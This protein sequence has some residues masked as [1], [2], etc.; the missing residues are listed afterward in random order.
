MSQ[1]SIQA[2]ARILK[3]LGLPGDLP[4]SSAQSILWNPDNWT[5]EII[6]AH[7][8][9][10]ADHRANNPYFEK[11]F[12]GETASPLY[13][14][15]YPEDL[16]KPQ[17]AAPKTKEK[18]TVSASEPAA[19]PVGIPEG[20]DKKTYGYFK[21]DGSLETDPVKI[22]A[23]MRIVYKGSKA[24]YN[25][26]GTERSKMVDTDLPS[27]VYKHPTS[28]ASVEITANRP[29]KNKENPGYFLSKDRE[30]GG[31]LY[32]NA[33]YGNRLGVSSLVHNVR[34]AYPEKDYNYAPINGPLSTV[35]MRDGT[36][37]PSLHASEFTEDLL[38]THYAPRAAA[39][40]AARHEILN[41]KTNGDTKNT[42]EEDTR[43]YRAGNGYSAE[44]QPEEE[45]IPQPEPIA[46][47][48]SQ[49]DGSSNVGQQFKDLKSEEA[50]TDGQ[51][52]WGE[53]TGPVVEPSEG[54]YANPWPAVR[55][56]FC[57]DVMPGQ[58]YA[59]NHASESAVC[60]KARNADPRSNWA[61]SIGITKNFVAFDRSTWSKEVK[62]RSERFQ[63][64]NG[65]VHPETGE[66]V[67]TGPTEITPR[68]PEYGD[69][70]QEPTREDVLR[71]WGDFRPN[72][73]E[74]YMEKH[75][76]SEDEL[77][78]RGE[79]DANK[80]ASAEPA[81]A[82]KPLTCTFCGETSSD[83][84]SF[85]KEH[86]IVSNGWCKSVVDAHNSLNPK[87]PINVQ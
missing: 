35:P 44:A 3:R 41:S 64:V 16:T 60:A 38:R 40:I 13:K 29:W 67:H 24:Y 32:D 74:Y 50:S 39:I 34:T 22:A 82:P 72:D 73:L 1:Y 78:P 57:G 80:E 53:R 12:T 51:A 75:G 66:A 4:T 2:R 86:Q 5:P 71:M 25:D 20:A 28:K 54:S 76:I 87:F 45:S 70:D 68:N 58:H 56:G 8:R 36:P 79:Y 47:P 17:A 23:A 77:K 21:D 49:L 42:A 14:G 19:V 26:N 9:H 61:K 65:P 55:C 84:S 10:I 7:S 27:L 81:A 33:D 18:P 48:S 6:A 62:T 30:E 43:I 31:D 69:G 59:D 46:A 52:K 83:E 37:G 11:T 85:K 63:E 15:F